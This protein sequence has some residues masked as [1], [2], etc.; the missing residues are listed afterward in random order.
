MALFALC[1]IR[2]TTVGKPIPKVGNLIISK[3][4]GKL[5][6]TLSVCNSGH[7]FLPIWC[8]HPQLGSDTT[9][10]NTL[11]LKFG[12]KVFPVVA[13]LLIVVLPIEHA[14]NANDR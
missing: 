2:I 13:V 3:V 4:F 5:H 14:D 7:S 10:F 8:R 1:V 12:I 6:D 9:Q 11:L